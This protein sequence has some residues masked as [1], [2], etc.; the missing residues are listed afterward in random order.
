M[1]NVISHFC[2]EGEVIDVVPYG[3]GHINDTYLLRYK[4][5]CKSYYSENEYRYF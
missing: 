3:N 5:N 1:K 2:F 4:D